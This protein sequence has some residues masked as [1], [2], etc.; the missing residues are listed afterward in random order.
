MFLFCCGASGSSSGSRRVGKAEESARLSSSFDHGVTKQVSSSEVA[1]KRNLQA[2]AGL[3]GDFTGLCG[4]LS[5]AQ[6][7]KKKEQAWTAF[8]TSSC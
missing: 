3:I 1:S 6:L 7:P 4:I 8:F 5:G 2:H